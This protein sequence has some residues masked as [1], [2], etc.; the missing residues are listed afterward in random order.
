MWDICAKA[1]RDGRVNLHGTG[2][3]SRDF[4]HAADVARAAALVA[5]AAPLQ[6]EA[7][8]VGTG[9]ETRI[10]A[11]AALLLNVL[12]SEA[13]VSFSGEARAGDPANWRADVSRLVELGFEPGVRVEEGAAVYGKWAK[14]ELCR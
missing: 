7:Y 8:N 5:R 3:E 4:V 11:L 1:L 9:T 10:D 12:G 14:G 2:T 6:A 13:P